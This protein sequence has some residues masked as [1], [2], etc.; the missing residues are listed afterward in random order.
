M[1]IKLLDH[2]TVDTVGATFKGDGANA[3]VEVYS[4]NFGGGSVTIEG[5]IIKD[6]PSGNW[7][8]LTY[9]GLPAVFTA[10]KILKL[11]YVSVGMNI[12]AKLTGSTSPAAVTV[13]VST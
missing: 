3:I 12:R 5:D 7:V 8:T 4:T 13:Q 6:S 2:V 10:N 1:Q 9:A 11:D